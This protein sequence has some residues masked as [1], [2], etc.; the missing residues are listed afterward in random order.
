MYKEKIFLKLPIRYKNLFTIYPPSVNDVVGNDKF[1]QYRS[2]LTISQE[3]IEDS[4]AEKMPDKK[5]LKIPTPFELLLVNSY[6]SKE[7]YEMA[8]EAFYFFTKTEI[9]ILFDL[10]VIVIGNLEEELKRIKNIEELKLLKEEDFFDFQNQIRLCIGEE[11][12][13]P[14]NPN[15]DPRVK[16]IKAKARYRDKIKAKQ[17]KGLSLETNLIAIC[18]MGIGI[19]PLNI[20]E[21]S[22]ASISKLTRTFQEKEKYQM[23]IDSLLAGAKDIKPKYW[24]RN[25]NE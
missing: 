20:G 2:I 21:L 8:K 4:F 3:E 10:K 24:I 13:A 15:E 7:F 5:D 25:L 23:D 16:R 11:E 6:N 19:T 18:C 22:Y 14:P 17:K 9:S 12:K 1:L